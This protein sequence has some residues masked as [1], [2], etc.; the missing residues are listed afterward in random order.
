LGYVV[1]EGEKMNIPTPL[2]RKLLDMIHE[3]EAGRR[4]FRQEN[5][6]ELAVVELGN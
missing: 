1:R 3:L 4:Q 5:Y 2:C 6:D